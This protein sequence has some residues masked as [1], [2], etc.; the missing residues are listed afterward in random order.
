[1]I[2][3]FSSPSGAGQTSSEP[4]DTGPREWRQHCRQH[5]QPSFFGANLVH[6]KVKTVSTTSFISLYWHST[7]SCP[8]NF[9]LI[10]SKTC[11]CIATEKKTIKRFVY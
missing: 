2:T 1:M 10:T 8:C 9:F 4:A 11:P 3:A 7:T 6:V 5:V